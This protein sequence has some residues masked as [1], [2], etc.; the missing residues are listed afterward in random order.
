[1]AI[2]T[3]RG[4]GGET[5]LGDGSR[6]PKDSPRVEAYGALDEACS[7]VGFARAA[8]GDIVP[9]A[10]GP[11]EPSGDA[12]ALDLLGRDLA[13]LQQRLMNCASALAMPGASNGAPAISPADV[14]A[15]EHA[16]DR[17]AALS[18]PWR[19]FVLPA[20]CEAA[21]R[22]HLARAITRRAERRLDALARTDALPDNVSAFVNRASDLLFSAAGAANALSGAAEQPWDPDQPAPA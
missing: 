4:D 7:A 6:V 20:G 16:I 14:A 17:C 1:M 5:S 9:S 13:F 19:G 3:G 11:D 2:Y 22:L 10:T 18:G 15:V 8:L 12:A 21:V